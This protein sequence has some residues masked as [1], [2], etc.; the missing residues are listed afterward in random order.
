MEVGSSVE[1]DG[2]YVK[3]Q[4]RHRV[5]YFHLSR[6]IDDELRIL[7]GEQILHLESKPE[8]SIQILREFFLSDVA[9]HLWWI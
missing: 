3:G 7:L 5:W 1:E 4:R 6:E 9:V 8:L 2:G